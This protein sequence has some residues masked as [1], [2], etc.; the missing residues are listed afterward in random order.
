MNL[1]KHEQRVLHVLALGGEIQYSRNGSSKINEI[2]CFSR[3]GHILAD[4][5]IEIF[6]RLKNKKLIR[7]KNSAPYRITALGAS[8]VKSQMFQR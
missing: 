8:S 7:S 5:T 2:A 3:E 4:C 1:S 6:Q